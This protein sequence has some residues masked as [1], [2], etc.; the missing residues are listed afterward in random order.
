MAFGTPVV[1]ASVGG[2][3]E[4]ITDSK[5]GVLVP[6]EDIEAFYHGMLRLLEHPEQ[7][8]QLGENGRREIARRF[9]WGHNTQAYKELFTELICS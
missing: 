6:P 3:P 8:R 2:L 1:A 7:A 5:N 9:T 4:L